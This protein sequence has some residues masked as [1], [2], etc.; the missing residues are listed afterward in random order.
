M[1]SSGEVL[2]VL[3]GWAETRSRLRVVVRSSEML[4]SAFCTVYKANEERVAFWVGL[5]EDKNAVEFVLSG[6]RF[7][8]T[9]V[10]PEQADLSVGAK[11]ESGIVG[12]RGMFRLAIMLL[13]PQGL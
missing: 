11:V 10:P 2:L 1:I 8:F 3:N 9:D 5:E 4:F 6:C 13:K 7:E 12:V